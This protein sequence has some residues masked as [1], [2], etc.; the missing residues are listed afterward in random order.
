M[1]TRTELRISYDEK[2]HPIS[3]TCGGCEEKMPT[4]PAEMQNSADVISWFAG[5]YIE[6]RRL[7]HSKDDRRRTPRD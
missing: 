6:H 2:M 4:P 7:K 5:K 1:S 3:A